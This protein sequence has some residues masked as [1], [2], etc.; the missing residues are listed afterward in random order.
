MKPNNKRVRRDAGITQF[1]K[2]NFNE[3]KYARKDKS[4]FFTY[5][6]QGPD[7]PKAPNLWLEQKNDG[8]CL[9]FSRP[10]EAVASN[11]IKIDGGWFLSPLST[12]KEAIKLI[13]GHMALSY[14][15][16]F[17]YNRLGSGYT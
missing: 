3:T 9:R 17:V 7:A 16:N 10:H 13:H 15:R 6:H 8:I 5:S 11:L 14:A 12:E 1:L 2:D 4:Y